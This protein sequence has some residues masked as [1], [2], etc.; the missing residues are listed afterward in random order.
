VSC[1]VQLPDGRVIED[2]RGNDRDDPYERFCKGQFMTIQTDLN[3]LKTSNGQ[4]RE[5]LFNGLS[6]L[7]GEV[8]SLRKSIMGLLVGVIIALLT[9][10]GFGVMQMVRTQQLIQAAETAQGAP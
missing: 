9:V 1:Q 10:G 8:A 4:I 3:S 5:K 2:R 7:P 6:S